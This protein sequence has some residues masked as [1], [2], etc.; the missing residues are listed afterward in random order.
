MP[1]KRQARDLG[2]KAVTRENREQMTQNKS[3]RRNALFLVDRSGSEDT[4]LIIQ[5]RDGSLTKEPRKLRQPRAAESRRI[6]GQSTYRVEFP[7][8]LL[9]EQNSLIDRII[10]FAFDTLG[11]RQINVRVREAE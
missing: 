11:A 4:A 1:S 8:A 2:S 7:A 3:E 6:G 9:D 5:N 10:S